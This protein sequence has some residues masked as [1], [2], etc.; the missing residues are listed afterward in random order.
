MKR[1]PSQIRLQ[2]AKNLFLLLVVDALGVSK[3]SYRWFRYCLQYTWKLNLTFADAQI[4]LA[5][6]GNPSLLVSFE[7]KLIII[8]VLWF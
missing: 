4:L 5:P 1:S 7:R 3:K 6:W 2:L 8:D